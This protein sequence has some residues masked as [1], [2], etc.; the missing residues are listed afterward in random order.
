MNYSRNELQPLQYR[1]LIF[2][3]NLFSSEKEELIQTTIVGNQPI[4]RESLPSL[5][6]GEFVVDE[7]LQ[8][9]RRF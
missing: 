7:N 8:F 3:I 6:D 9:V 5:S 4:L 1:W 2:M